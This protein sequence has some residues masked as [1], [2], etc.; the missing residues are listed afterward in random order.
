[1]AL[2]TLK[3]VKEIG[4]YPVITQDD[5]KAHVPRV[6]Q[7]GQKLDW[8]AWREANPVVVD[9]DHN[10]IAFKIQNGAIKEAGVNGC[11][12]DTLIHAAKMIIAGLNAKFPC[13][14]NS[15][16]IAALDEAIQWLEIRTQDREARGVE[17]TSQA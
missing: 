15:N 8:T 17:G 2:E 14:E 6:H 9:H 3:D 13:R 5:I 10:T 11:Q 12:V 16:A 7:S 4:G 1:M